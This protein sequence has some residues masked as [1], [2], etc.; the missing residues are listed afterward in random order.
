MDEVRAH[1]EA[2]CPYKEDCT[3]SDIIIGTS[4]LVLIGIGAA[5]ILAWLRKKS[6]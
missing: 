3:M 6:L 4:L 5:S 1:C 2:C